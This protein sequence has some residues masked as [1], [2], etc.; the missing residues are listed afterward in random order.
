MH[1]FLHFIFMMANDLKRITTLKPETHTSFYGVY[2]ILHFT[3]RWEAGRKNEP[4]EN[5][6]E[7]KR[8]KRSFLMHR[9]SLCVFVFFFP[10]CTIYIEGRIK[11]HEWLVLFGCK[12]IGISVF[13][14]IHSDVT[15]MHALGKRWNMT[16]KWCKIMQ[17]AEQ[18][19]QETTDDQVQRSAHVILSN[20]DSLQWTRAH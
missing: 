10:S 16:N 8:S 3:H 17:C 11:V 1:F 4:T 9:N 12:I 19:M 13:H 14:A 6:N 15:C 2:A 20:F 5:V 7:T 18:L